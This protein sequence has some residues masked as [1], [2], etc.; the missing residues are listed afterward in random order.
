MHWKYGPQLRIKA[1]G[2][3]VGAAEEMVET[4]LSV[5]CARQV[6]AS[7]S[8]STK[9]FILDFCDMLEPSMATAQQ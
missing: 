1:L 4:G 5:G 8:Q 6:L 3:T 9:A 2:W 7:A